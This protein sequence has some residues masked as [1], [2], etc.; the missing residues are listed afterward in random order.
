MEEVAGQG[1]HAQVVK[2]LFYTKKESDVITKKLKA[3]GQKLYSEYFVQ[4]DVIEEEFMAN[5]NNVQAWDK[6][7]KAQEFLEKTRID[8]L[9]STK[10][11]MAKFKGNSL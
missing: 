7:N 6:L 1:L 10:N 2:V 4:I 11:V 8:K 9:E 3:Q 5:L